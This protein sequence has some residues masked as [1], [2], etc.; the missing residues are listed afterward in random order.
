MKTQLLHN[1]LPVD[2]TGVCAVQ[3]TSRRKIKR[4]RHAPAHLLSVMTAMGRAFVLLAN[5]T[6]NPEEASK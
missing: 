4:I 1:H 2:V 6:W 3:L 5:I